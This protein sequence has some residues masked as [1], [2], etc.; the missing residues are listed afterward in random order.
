MTRSTPM[1]A[2]SS[3]AASDFEKWSQALFFSRSD[4]FDDD[5]GTEESDNENTQFSEP[6]PDEETVPEFE[7]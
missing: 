2:A 3:A 5:I 6:L 4:G 7:A 1:P